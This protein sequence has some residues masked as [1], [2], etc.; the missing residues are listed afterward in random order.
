MKEPLVK[1]NVRRSVLKPRIA[2]K[3]TKPPS[4]AESTA[5]S[6][7]VYAKPT[8]TSVTATAARC[9]NRLRKRLYRRAIKSMQ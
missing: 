8:G 1:P 2:S 7:L 3:I 4:N 9:T 5:G 6:A